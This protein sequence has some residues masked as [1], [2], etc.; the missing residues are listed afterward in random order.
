ME[1]LTELLLV[2]VLSGMIGMGTAE[3][4][5]ATIR[6]IQDWRGRK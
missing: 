4:I 6:F 1:P 5:T 3:F 2:I